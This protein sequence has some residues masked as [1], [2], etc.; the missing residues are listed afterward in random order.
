MV[1]YNK[2]ITFLGTHFQY[3]S[4]T[5]QSHTHHIKPRTHIISY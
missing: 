4:H 1:F 3:I 5:V 2:T